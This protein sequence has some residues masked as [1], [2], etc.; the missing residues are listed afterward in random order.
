MRSDN[1]AVSDLAVDPVAFKKTKHIMRAA[2]F[3]RDLT[4][5]EF[6]MVKW[7]SGKSNP[8]DVFTK[9]LY[10]PLADFRALMVMLDR[11]DGVA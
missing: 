6:F 4:A 10:L 2:E 9:V 11:L 8:A 3:L 1:K 7:I 5:C